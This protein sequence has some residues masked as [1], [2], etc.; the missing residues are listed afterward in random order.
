MDSRLDGQAGLRTLRTLEPGGCAWTG[1]HA[2]RREHAGAAN[3]LGLLGAAHISMTPPAAAATTAMLLLDHFARLANNLLLTIRV[4]LVGAATV[5]ALRGDGSLAA[6]AA[7][8]LQGVGGFS[9]GFCNTAQQ[10]QLCTM[11]HGGVGS[12]PYTAL[13]TSPQFAVV[14]AGHDTPS[15]SHHH[16]NAPAGSLDQA[17]KQSFSDHQGGTC[18][19]SGRSRTVWRWEFGRH[20]SR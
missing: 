12:D 13:H 18:R 17:R 14:R 5:L 10:A 1:P 6:T 8:D 7:D 19:C 15:Y 9:G 20:G 2:G 16:C 3:E 11:Y 4:A